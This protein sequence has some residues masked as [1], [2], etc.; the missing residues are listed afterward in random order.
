MNQTVMLN[1]L[2]RV[3]RIMAVI[4]TLFSITVGYYA[5]T[6][7]SF[8][9]YV[10]VAVFLAIS[11]FTSISSYKK[12]FEL[13]SAFIVSLIMSLV[14]VI[15]ISSP[16][17]AYLLLFPVSISAMY[18]NR[19]LFIITAL[20]SNAGAIL[21]ELISGIG[22]S[23]ILRSFII[24]DL[25]V[26]MLFFITKWGTD[27][28]K[29][30]VLE[31]EKANST[32]AELK[33]TMELVEKNTLSL[34]TEIKNCDSSLLE[35]KDLSSGLANTV[36]EVTKGVFEQTESISQ[37]SKMMNDA[38]SKI[39]ETEQISKQLGSISTKANEVVFEGYQN[40]DQMDKQIDIISN[41]VTESLS[42]V[43][44]LL[45]NMNEIDNFLAG[46]SEIAEQTNLLALNAA[47]EAA[48]AGDSGKGFAVVAD[49][50]RN[51][52]EKSAHTV[53]QINHMMGSIKEKNKNVLEKVK[54]GNIAT[55][56]GVAI[57][58]Q[59][60]ESFKKINTSFSDI[61]KSIEIELKMIENTTSI[62]SHIRRE[63]ESIA[64]ISEENSAS[65]EEIHTT[66]QDQDANIEKIYMSIHDIRNSSENLKEVFLEKNI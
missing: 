33:K 15:L 28:I 62:F 12:R 36:H 1:Y 8:E 35:V 49:E 42:T 10:I 48:R 3:N 55:Q 18:M 64:S 52:A 31:S 37:I 56:E 19:K 38:N 20:S 27:L 30:A 5:I 39:I 7:K 47:I 58:R 4:F 6:G 23:T 50:V 63:A 34:N 26:L 46:I 2:R 66:M 22:I 45:N 32:L 14:V 17:L 61:S 40:M 51:L 59:V 13:L 24:I 44:E 53:K 16:D 41:S 57:V 25:I 9:Y 60:N 43:S 54:S 21:K 29:L 65:T 11:V